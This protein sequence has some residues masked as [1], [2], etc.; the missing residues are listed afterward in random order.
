MRKKPFYADRL[1]NPHKPL[2]HS[3]AQPRSIHLTPSSP[4][5]L[6]TLHVVSACRYPF[7][8]TDVLIGGHRI[9]WP[10]PRL[11][12]E[13]TDE[14]IAWVRLLS[15]YPFQYYPTLL[16][17]CLVCSQWLPASR[18]QLFQHIYI[19][20]SQNYDLF[21]SRVLSQSSMRIYLSHVRTLDLAAFFE[22]S[23]RPSSIPFAYAF[24]GH[25][26]K[27][28]SLWL[29][30]GGVKKYLCRHPCTPLALSRFSS[31]Q[32]LRID[33]NE[34]PSWGDV[35]RV[36]TSLPNLTVLSMDSDV[37]WSEPAV[38]LSPLLASPSSRP[39]LVALSYT[40]DHDCSAGDTRR[41]I[42]LLTWLASTSTGS[43]LRRLTLDLHLSKVT[44]ADVC[45]AAFMYTVA[46]CV[47]EL[48]L[49]ISSDIGQSI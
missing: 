29:A 43:S 15:P 26:P 21:V 48:S 24:V 31:I 38:E 12:A 47:E 2:L 20:R 44:Y 14:I 33:H 39:R 34:F 10:G 17:C 27:L 16:D 8:E 40:W 9:K 35:R 3:S 45:G 23:S 49:K 28:T 41:A 46:C 5:L 18:H 42:Q 7:D 19:P 32:E 37:R 6:Y 22:E 1:L 36:L 4:P 13:L 25:L 11:P 30:K